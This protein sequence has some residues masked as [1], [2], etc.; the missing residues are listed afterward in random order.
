MVKNVINI[1]SWVELSNNPVMHNIFPNYIR[2]LTAK[3]Y[4]TK[5]VSIFY[6]LIL[7][8]RELPVYIA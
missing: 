2:V 5:F 8:E 3:L 1:C 4:K 7:L 6:I